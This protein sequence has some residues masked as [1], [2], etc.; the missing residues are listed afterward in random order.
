MTRP[1]RNPILLIALAAVALVGA[2]FLCAGPRDAVDWRLARAVLFESDDWGLCGF[3]PDAS[4]LD[5]LDRAGLTPG[6]FPE[7]YWGTTLEDSATVARLHRLLQRSRGRAGLPAVFQPNYIMGSL[8]AE[9]QGGWRLRVLPDLPPAYA[10]P[11]LWEAVDAARRDGVWVPE[12]HGLL[13]YDRDARYRAAADPDGPAAAAAR[14]GVMLFPGASEAAELGPDR[15]QGARADV[16]WAVAAF[17]DRFGR[18]PR[19]TVAPDYTWTRLHETLWAEAGIE[20]V[21]GKREQRR[22]HWGNGP[23]ARLRKVAERAWRRLTEPRLVYLERN[24]RF[25]PAQ[26]PDPSAT[27]RRCLDEIGNAWSRGEP[28]I[29]EVHRVNFAH[30]DS[31]VVARGFTAFAELLDGLRPLSG[32]APQFLSDGEAAQLQ[33]CGVS[34]RRLGKELV[35]RNMTHSRRLITVP[36]SLPDDPPLHFFLDPG[37]IVRI[38]F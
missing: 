34:W 13:H 15:D 25:E 37:T 9:P 12:L 8:S 20:A 26:D 3:V 29:V 27:V 18:P 2:A 10:R 22:P 5:S 4:A 21:Q 24:C 31:T 32:P 11:G 23:A 30:V 38:P 1:H 35:L 28:A 14:R 36:G 7:V 17:R 6:P 16:M 19:S 33:R